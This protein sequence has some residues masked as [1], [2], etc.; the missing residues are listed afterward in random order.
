MLWCRS[1]SIY[2]PFAS[3]SLDPVSLLYLKIPELC[4]KKVNLRVCTEYGDL[5]DEGVVLGLESCLRQL[6]FLIS[7]GIATWHSKFRYIQQV[8]FIK[9]A[10]DTYLAANTSCTKPFKSNIIN[11]V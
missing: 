9:R 10:E 8:F 11:T 3:G 1:T 5:V 6:L 7:S 2:I 4:K